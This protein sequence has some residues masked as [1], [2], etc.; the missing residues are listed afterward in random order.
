MRRT[1]LLVLPL[2]ALFLAAS[3]PA[4][5][6]TRSGPRTRLMDDLNWMEFAELVPARIRT[7]ILSVGTLEPHGVINNGADNT[8]PIALAHAIAGR[9]GIDALIAPHLPYGVTGSLAPYPG[10]LRVPEDV[11]EPFIRS[12]LDGLAG[13]GFRDI[14]VLNGHGGGQTAILQ[15]VAHDVAIERGVNTLVINWW[16]LTSDITMRVFGTDGGHAGVN[17][18]AFVQAVD[19]SL[20]QR[21]RYTGPD[22][23]TANPAP[24]A[25]SAVP[26][27]SAITLYKPGEGWPTDFD[28]AKAQ[29][30]H[31]EVVERVASLVID[32]IEKWK[33]AGF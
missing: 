12:V 25:W 16:S 33:R 19:A 9:A 8:A 18:T 2:L 21:E 28:Q 30:Y 10:A 31:D 15:K 29:R 7:V 6:Q 17:E 3:M 24:G 26:F 32:T 20:V 13:N 4:A 23:A 11:Y 5:A 22:M 27:P 14:V 1:L